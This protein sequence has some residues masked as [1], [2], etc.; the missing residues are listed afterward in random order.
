MANTNKLT[1]DYYGG[2]VI[3]KIR[4]MFNLTSAQNFNLFGAIEEQSEVTRINNAQRLFDYYQGD[5]DAIEKHLQKALSRTF[6]SDDIAE[7]QLLY[8]PVLRRIIDKLC[9]VYKS[10]VWRTLEGEGATEKL[11]E[12]Y[13]NSDILQKQRYWYRMAKLFDTVLVRPVVRERNGEPYLN[14]DVF[15]PNKVTVI[16]KKDDYTQ[17]AAVVYQEQ[18]NVK[19]QNQLQTVY[20]TDEEHFIVDEDGNKKV[21]EGNPGN[22]NP[23]GE[24]PFE[25]LRLKETEDFWGDGQTVLANVEEKIDVL[26]V[27][28][29]DLLV[30][31]THGQPVFNN[32]RIEGEVQTG[33]RHPV[34]L[35]PSDPAQA[36]AF[37][38]VSPDGKIKDVQDAIDWII[39]KTAT[40]YG[41][42]RSAESGESQAASGYAKM[43]DNWDLME[44][45]AEEVEI[46]KDFEKRLYR[47][48]VIVCNYDMN[49][50]L[51]EE[52]FGVEF[53]EYDFPVDPSVDLQVKKEKMELGLWTPVDDIMEQDSSLTKDEAMDVLRENLKIRDEIKDMLGAFTRGMNEGPDQGDT[54]RSASGDDTEQTVG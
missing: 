24:L 22:K 36:A 30:M 38:F 23:Y 44:Q 54:G 26:L 8:L 1:G 11:D 34:M 4:T 17:P 16:P 9:I 48:T 15:T 45:R 12:L 35:I 47:K 7:F 53:D 40:M 39:T 14:Y 6:T 13:E 19:G 27:Q 28:L 49:A 2:G 29:M 41:L 10:G 52:G 51:P 46:L 5:A 21:L 33:P 43:L 50:G 25:V 20:W 18:V 3:Q 32:A 42:S 31:Q 37:S